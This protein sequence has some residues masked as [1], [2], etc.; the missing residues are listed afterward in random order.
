MKTQQMLLMAGAWAF[1]ALLLSATTAN[2]ADARRLEI[3]NVS[4]GARIQQSL[5]CGN[6]VDLTSPIARGYMQMTWLPPTRG[7]DVLVDL[8]K[9]TMFL[10]PFHVEANCNGVGGSVD[11]REIGA[12]LA[13]TVRFRATPTSE[14]GVYHIRI[15]K[16]QF[17]IY[18]TVINNLPIPQPEAIYKRPSEDVT[19]LIDV[20][21]QTVQL[22]IVLESKLHFR[23]GCDRDRCA[24]DEIHTGTIVTEVRGGRSAGAPP[25]VKCR[26]GREPHCK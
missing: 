1:S 22:Q 19:G 4:G 7:G 16:E 15:P 17:L 20:R 3:T 21:R 9:L 8:T 11:F 2:A 12:S 13:S 10:S 14:P 26:P 6:T 18:E 24:I 5:P 25:A 23:A